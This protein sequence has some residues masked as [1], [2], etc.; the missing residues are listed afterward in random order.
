MLGEYMNFFN[1][2]KKNE[3]LIIFIMFLIACIIK[4]LLV[5]PG[6]APVTFFD[7]LLYKE[8]AKYILNGDYMSSHYPPLY[9]LLLSL[10]FMKYSNNFYIIMQLVNVILSS[11]LVFPTWLLAKK[12]LD[13]K[14]SII[15]SLIVSLIPFQFVYP[16]LI[17]S[18]NLYYALI[19]FLIYIMI[20]SS[21]KLRYIDSTI[22]GITISFCLM[23]RYMT[24]ALL[25]F[26]ALIWC[27]LSYYAMTDKGLKL[28]QITKELLCKGIVIIISTLVISLPW[29]LVRYFKGYPILEIL[30]EDSIRY[31]TM[32]G[33]ENIFKWIFFYMSY[34]ILMMGPLLLPIVYGLIDYKN[35]FK[36]NGNIKKFIFIVIF[37]TI[38]ILFLAI[39]HSAMASYNQEI[40]HYIIGRYIMYVFPLWL[41]FSFISLT[42]IFSKN[43]ITKQIKNKIII[44]AL[45][46]IILIYLSY[47]TIIEGRFFNITNWFVMVHN[48]IDVYSFKGNGISFCIFTIIVIII[49][50]L[51]IVKKSYKL[52]NFML[53]LFFIISSAISFNAIEK[54]QANLLF[55]NN[56]V[57]K[58]KENYEKVY[59]GKNLVSQQEYYI[60][61]WEL[62]DIITEYETNIE[63]D[64]EIKNGDIILSTKKLPFEILFKYNSSYLYKCEQQIIK[65]E[66]TFPSEIAIGKKFN[67]QKSGK[68]AMAIK[69]SGFLPGCYVTVN[70]ERFDT[71]FGSP[72]NLSIIIDEKYY[73]ARDDL[74]IQVVYNNIKSNEVIIS[75]R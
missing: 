46:S 72:D 4:I 52:F 60:K 54:Q 66:K 18:E 15:I 7:E 63:N 48:A 38:P 25:P 73:A 31:V 71:T 69:G 55:N 64:N 21:E 36:S 17:F 8:N 50:I 19:I 47:L 56:I 33:F 75:V 22:M 2:I 49:L 14:D 28:Y 65:I 23:T 67:I 32:G 68:S 57:N 39:K 58:I 41:I 42:K 12:Y 44:S 34:F 13:N 20:I 3:K 9:S 16:R 53:I 10:S 24:Y 43:I 37:I 27:V 45:I 1:K 61:F 26:I 74:I 30:N 35:T 11:M 29:L 62:E 40:P 59:I 6:D 51:S 5:I 70:G